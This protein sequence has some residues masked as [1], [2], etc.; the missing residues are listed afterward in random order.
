MPRNRGVDREAR[1]IAEL[2]CPRCGARI[3][4]ACSYPATH[5][6]PSCCD[7]RRRA[8]QE[9][10]QQDMRVAVVIRWPDSDR[11]NEAWTYNHD[12]P[13]ERRDFARRADAALRAGASVTTR[14]A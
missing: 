7:E 10:H 6:R 13:E 14:R 5:G 2:P 1:A 11:R 4:D 12:D 8:W 9:R 3:G